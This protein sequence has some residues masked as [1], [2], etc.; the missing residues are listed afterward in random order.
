MKL[1]SSHWYPGSGVVLDCIY[2]FLIFG[3]FLTFI[4]LLLLCVW[5]MNREFIILRIV[6]LCLCV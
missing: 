2:L 4:V 3:I 1:S 5:S 6:F